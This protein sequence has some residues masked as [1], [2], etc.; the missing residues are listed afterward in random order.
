MAGQYIFYNFICLFSDRALASRKWFRV[1]SQ[2]AS[3]MY[4]FAELY[5]SIFEE[6]PPDSSCSIT[7]Q[8]IGVEVDDLF[9]DI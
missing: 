7:Y 1:L 9:N 6:F 3:L 4:K 8:K 5:D 2:V